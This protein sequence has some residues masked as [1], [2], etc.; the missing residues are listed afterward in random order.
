V[1]IQSRVEE[2]WSDSDRDK[3]E[4]FVLVVV[5]RIVVL[6]DDHQDYGL[7]TIYIL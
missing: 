4:G 5:G 3:V 2:E 6:K 1:F 7:L